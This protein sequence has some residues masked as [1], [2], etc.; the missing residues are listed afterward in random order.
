[1]EFEVREV[2][3]IGVSALGWEDEVIFPPDDQCRRLML[4]QVLLHF[5]IERQIGSVIV[6]DV[7]LNIIVSGPVK[8]RLV[9]GP[10]IRR[11]AA[12]V[13]NAVGVLEFCRLQREEFADRRVMLQSRGCAITSDAGLLPYRELDDAMGLTDT[14]GNTLADARTGKNGPPRRRC[15]RQPRD[16]RVPRSR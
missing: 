3:F 15:L 13:R 12:R 5:R 4:A 16:V 1:M 9:M 10:V 2:A 8:K 11:D 7:Q 6:E 14:G